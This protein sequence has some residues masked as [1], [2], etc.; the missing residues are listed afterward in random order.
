[1][2]INIHTHLPIQNGFNKIKK[3]YSLG[4]DEYNSK[5]LASNDFYCVGLHP[6]HIRGNGVEQLGHLENIIK[7][8]SENPSFVAI[9]ECGLDRCKLDDIC[10]EQQL[11]V[12]QNQ[13]SLAQKYDK[14]V[15][16]HCV[17]AYSEV[18]MLRN[19]LNLAN[20]NF[21]FHGYNGNEQTT[22]ELLKNT[23][24]YFSFGVSL[25]TNEKLQKV[26]KKIPTDKIFFETDTNK[27][28]NNLENLYQFAIKEL[29]VA[30]N[31]Q[32]LSYIIEN[33][34]Q[35]VFNLK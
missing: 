6:W 8:S 11:L 31:I 23:N 34:F 26:I 12:F 29:K 13:L 10:F 16:I 27:E 18:I 22:K 32:D 30:D 5:Q 33:N 4:I 17:K 14:T 3:V 28:A 19:K 21:I 9:G 20:L 7:N 15:V 24:N 25:L 2:L 1:M 35:E